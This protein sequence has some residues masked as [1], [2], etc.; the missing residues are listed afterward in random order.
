[1]AEA[2]FF[3]KE[4][5]AKEPTL[6]YLFYFFNGQRL[7]VSTGQKIHPK[8]WNNSSQTAKETRQFPGYAE[9]NTFLKNLAS[10]VADTHRKLL[11]DKETPTAERLKAGLNNFLQKVKRDDQ[12]FIGFVENMLATSNKSDTTKKQYKQLISRL[13]DFGEY[14]KKRIDFNSIDLDFYSQFTNYLTKEKNYSINTVGSTIKNIKVFM[15]EAV[16]RG[17]TKNVHFKSKKFKKLQ[18][19]TENI[20]LSKKEIDIMYELDLSGKPSLERV[21]DMF[22]IGCYTGLRFSDLV[23]IQERNLIDNKTKFK[24]KTE[25]TGEVVIIPLHPYVKA[26]LN[27]YYGILPPDISNQK[28]NDYL[29]EVGKLA[30]LKSH[31]LITSTKGGKKQSEGFNKFELISTHT[32]RRSFA[33]N[34]YLE[35]VPTLSIMKITGH[36]TEKAFLT[37]IKMTQE[38]NANK[39]ILHPF[40]NN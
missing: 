32:A 39:L 27:K 37:Y 11:N 8:F 5:N 38:D 19:P 26:I 25:K 16:E 1:M 6:V 2:S 22:I 10:C 17:L 24:V 31:V 12:D 34:A 20:Y 30:G 18:E 40:F 21:R 29:K 7:K 35:E 4:P 36:K 28:M 23:Q 3:L 33:T 13:K 14:S 9:F 15:N